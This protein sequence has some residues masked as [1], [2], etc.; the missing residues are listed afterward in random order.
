MKQKNAA[1]NDSLNRVKDELRSAERDRSLLED[2]KRRMQTQLDDIQR[3]VAKLEASL[4]SS[5]QVF[6]VCFFDFTFN[7]QQY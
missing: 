2:E 7:V 6:N 1:L 4:E 3:Q 5:N